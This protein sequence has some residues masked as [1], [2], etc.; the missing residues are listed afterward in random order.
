[1][2]SSPVCST[3]A[4]KGVPIFP[5]RIVEKPAFLKM[6]SINEVVVVLPFEPVMPIKRP[7][8]KRS[9]SSTS[10]QIVM[11]LGRAVCSKDAS[12]GTPGLGTIRSCSRNVFSR[13]PPNSSFTPAARSGASAS[14][15]SF[16]DR[17]SVA[18]TFAARAAQKSEVATPVLASPTTST[19]LPRNSNG[20]AIYLAKPLNK[21]ALLP[22]LQGRQCKQ[23]K[24]QRCDP[25][26]H[27][28]FRFAPTQQLEMVM[29]GRHAKNALAAQLERTHLQDHGERLDHEN[30]ANE[31]EKD[32]LL[33]DDGD[34]AQG[35]AQRERA[36]VAHENLR[37][38]RVVP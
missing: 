31:K 35:P 2:E 15:I 17:V 9:A 3:R 27:D 24:N 5:A 34:H 7:C 29:N 19:R 11:P 14:P 32:F 30:A 26:P 37:G 10:L 6:C 28:D 20:F 16:S 33:D 23:R 21:N 8:R 18:V 22:Q 25:K 4:I 13:W 12:A 1:M 36:H 38:M